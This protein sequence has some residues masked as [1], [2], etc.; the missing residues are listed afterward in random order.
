M[1]IQVGTYKK[2]CTSR[3][4]FC[5]GD[6][7]ISCAPVWGIGGPKIFPALHC[8]KRFYEPLKTKI[9]FSLGFHDF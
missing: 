7:A 5:R 6:A 4:V 3:L 8:T 2:V 9:V 1:K